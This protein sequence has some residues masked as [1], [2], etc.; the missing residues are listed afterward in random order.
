MADYKFDGKNLRYRGAT[1][2]NVSGDKIRKGTGSSTVA[3]IKDESIREGVGSKVIANVK[4]M[5]IRLGSGSTRIGT[6]K[7]IDKLIDGPGGV[8][9]AALWFCFLR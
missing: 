1:I 9:K 3:N 7:D 8:T 2:A 5:D 6:M 4:G